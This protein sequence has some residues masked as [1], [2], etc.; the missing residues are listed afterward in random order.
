M[1]QPARTIG[2]IRSGAVCFLRQSRMDFP[3]NAGIRLCGTPPTFCKPSHCKIGKRSKSSATKR[4]FC[5]S[6]WSISLELNG[7]LARIDSADEKRL[8]RRRDVLKLLRRFM[9]EF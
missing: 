3:S 7:Q 1:L 9:H 4:P 8:E 2:R 6:R 5:N